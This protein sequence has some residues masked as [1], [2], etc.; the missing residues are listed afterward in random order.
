MNDTDRPVKMAMPIPEKNYIKQE[1]RRLRKERAALNAL[2]RK[3]S[4]LLKLR[5]QVEELNHQVRQGDLR[6]MDLR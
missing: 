2:A 4:N 3:R 1:M 6:P 5:H